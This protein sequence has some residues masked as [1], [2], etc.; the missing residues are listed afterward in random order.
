MIDC[1]DC[2]MWLFCER[3]GNCLCKEVIGEFDMDGNIHYNM[4]GLKN[5][6]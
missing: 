4:E 2:V 6:E 1:D 5:G 3:E